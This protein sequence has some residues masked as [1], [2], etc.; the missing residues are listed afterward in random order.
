MG[1]F[2]SRRLGLGL[3]VAALSLLLC[4]GVGIGWMLWR[5]FPLH[6]ITDQELLR[7][8]VE[9]WKKAGE[10]GYGANYQIFEQQAAQ[11]YYEDATA[12]GRLFKRVEDVQWSIVELVKIRAENG[13]IKGAKNAINSLA[14]SALQKKAA[15]VVALIQAQDGDLSGALETIA[16]FDESDE[17][18]LAYG[19]HQI[20][21]GDFEGALDT[22]G[23]T[24]S[25]YQLFY[26]IGDALR[27]RGQQGR[28]RKLSA[29]MKD[30]KFAALFLEC[31]RFTLWDHPE[32]VRV[33]QATPC[34]DAYLD[35]TRGKFAEADEV[36]RKN[37][38]SNV[39]FVAVRQYEVDPS[40][41]ERL[42]RDA[43]NPQDLAFGLGQFAAVAARKG[44]IVEALRL[45]NDLQSV[46][47]GEKNKPLAEAR[48]TDAIHHIA[49]A[50]TIKSGPKAV[51]KWARSRPTTEQRT[52]A[53]IGMA[54]ALGHATARRH[55][56]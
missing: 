34:D 2:L 4:V 44:N 23:R 33:I 22:A 20:Q 14:G 31:A 53:L 45:L 3:K 43:S 15:E 39:S 46:N 9:E 50:W 54:E 47:L 35:A 36:I 42:L 25:G 52:W 49:R 12:T 19:S 29:H 28:A 51:L 27:T 17:V 5:Q 26:D 41:A 21:M 1:L 56:L 37:G 32:E 30:R 11:G 16:P 13:D 7:E 40:G 18:F 8:A 55:C 24:K 48:V 10:P 38:C 6:K